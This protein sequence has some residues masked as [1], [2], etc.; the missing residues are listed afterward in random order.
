MELFD[1][2]LLAVPVG[3]VLA[4][5]AAVWF[6]SGWSLLTA[7]LGALIGWLLGRVAWEWFAN[8]PVGVGFGSE[9]EGYDWV[10]GTAAL[11]L[12][13]GAVLGSV[14]AAKRGQR[15]RAT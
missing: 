14:L 4:I 5:V 10:A 13:I 9:F 1:F 6:R 2:S 11:G 7:L 8:K 3:V 15:P 12:L